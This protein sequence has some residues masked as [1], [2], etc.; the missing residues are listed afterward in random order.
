MDVFLGKQQTLVF[1]ARCFTIW[2]ALTPFYFFSIVEM[3]RKEGCWYPSLLDVLTHLTNWERSPRPTNMSDI[4]NIIK[5]W[6]W[7][8]SFQNCDK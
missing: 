5:H 3:W 2:A 4:H 7:K 1:L 6:N 8:S